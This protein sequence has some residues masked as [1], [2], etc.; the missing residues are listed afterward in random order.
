SSHLRETAFT[1]TFE[2]EIPEQSEYN[3]IR[4]KI[5]DVLPMTADEAILQMN[6][7]GH[8]FFMFKNGNT[9]VVNVVYKRNDG[10]YGLIIP[11]K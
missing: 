2:E 10:Q 9:G 5:I 6:L 11:E 3:V 4:T 1:E 7:I 8:N